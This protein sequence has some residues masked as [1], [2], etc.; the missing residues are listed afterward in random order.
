MSTRLKV[1]VI[2]GG[3]SVQ[4]DISLASAAA[5]VKHLDPKIYEVIPVGIDKKGHLHVHEIEDLKF[6]DKIWPVQTDQSFE[7]PSLIHDTKFFTPVDVVLSLTYGGDYENGGLQGLLNLAQVPYVSADVLGAAIGVNKDIARRLACGDGIQSPAYRLM[8]KMDHEGLWEHRV[9]EM[10][11]ACGWPLIV[12]P[13]AGGAS[14]GV[15]RVHH[16]SGAL[17]AIKNAFQYD[18]EVLI[19]Q[20]ISGRE[21]EVVVIQDLKRQQLRASIPGEID[22]KKYD[23]CY[24]YD[25]KHHQSHLVEYIAPANIDADWIQTIRQT[26]IEIFKRV[27]CKNMARIEFFFDEKNQTLYF[28]E[29]NTLLSSPANHL[30]AMIW[31]KTGLKFDELLRLLIET[32]MLQFQIKHQLVTEY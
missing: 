3:N 18:E 16:F 29:I 10:V 11:D 19:E 15:V 22:F 31:D 23:E 6:E 20:A 7:I 14:I 27:K 28:N 26:A 24:S 21:I 5:V 9:R 8:N 1:A 17:E 25:L 30:S 12:K 2:Y 32:A 13:C 4:H